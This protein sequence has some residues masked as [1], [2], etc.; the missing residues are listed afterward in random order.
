MKI[1]V[2]SFFVLL[3][4][5]TLIACNKD[6]SIAQVSSKDSTLTEGNSKGKMKGSNMKEKVVKSTDEWKKVLPKETFCV[7]FEKETERA[8]SGKYDKFYE[9]GIYKC[10]AC[11]TPLFS[12]DTKFNSGSGWPSFFKPISEDRIKN[13]DDNSYGMHRIE[14]V[15]TKCG[16]HLGHVFDDGP[17]PTG[18]RYCMNSVALN[19]EKAKEKN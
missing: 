14:V 3:F 16:G 5:I 9:N 4:A 1:V 8:F 2:L 13:I 15:C 17:K 10:A 18:L 19:F 12:S 7:M 11:G 6:K